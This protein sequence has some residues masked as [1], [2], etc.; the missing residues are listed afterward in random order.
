MILIWLNLYF[1]LLGIIFFSKR[2]FF[3]QGHEIVVATAIVQT[4]IVFSTIETL[5][6]VRSMLISYLR[7]EQNEITYY[8]TSVMIIG[9]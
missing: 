9:G 6:N 4:H 7:I 2:P 1:V 5:T 8:I 3:F